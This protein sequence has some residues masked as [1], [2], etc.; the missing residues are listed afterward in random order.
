M[1][2]A[3]RR[4]KVQPGKAG[5]VAKR[6]REGFVPIV[7]KSKGY[8]AYYIVHLGHDSISSISVF[9][10]QE[11]ADES[12][13]LAADW[14]KTNIASLIVGAPE[15]TSGEATVHHSA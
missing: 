9:D 3:I 13:K 1:H 12:T 6:A 10:T 15:V 5:E 11:E 4:Y 7:S 2:V 14:V 8:K